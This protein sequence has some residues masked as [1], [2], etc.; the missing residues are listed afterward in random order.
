M[1]ILALGWYGHNNIGD[2]SYK[3]T[4]PMFLHEHDVRFTD[5][6]NPKEP[7]QLDWCD[8]VVLGGG[9][10]L[11]PYFLDQVKKVKK[12]VYAISIGGEEKI[13]DKPIF[14]HVWSRESKTS[15]LMDDIGQK[16]SYMPD[17]AYLLQPNAENGKEWLH[18]TFKE[19][20]LDLYEKKVVVVMNSYLISGTQEAK[21]R[22]AFHFLDASYRLAYTF[23]NTSA[24]FI[25]LPFGT[26]PSCD[27]RVANSWINSKCKWWKKNC[28]IHDR[29]SVKKTLDIIAASDAVISTRLHSSI[30]SH[31]SGV[32]FIDLT[33]HSKNEEFLASVGKSDSSVS[34]WNFNCDLLQKKLENNLIAEKPKVPTYKSLIE[35]EINDL[36]F[37]EPRKGS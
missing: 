12:P 34:Y 5:F 19:E 35:K 27:D 14:S 1:K 13:L 32:P 17:L 36:R 4:L 24:S 25:F 37:I 8:M 18:D 3:F 2:E 30:F 15:K 10:V 11:K 20:C 21:P 29:L 16:N 28:V 22:D 6:L 9:N 23:D 26:D 33:H 7:A 31:L